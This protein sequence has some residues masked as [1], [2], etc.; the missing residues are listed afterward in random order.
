MAVVAVQVGESYKVTSGRWV[1]IAYF[2]LETNR[3]TK[4]VGA[5]GRS[6]NLTD[7]IATDMV[8]YNL[9]IA[10]IATWAATKFV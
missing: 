2:D 10:D 5:D 9:A 4:I 1:L 7:I 3:I 6:P 8:D